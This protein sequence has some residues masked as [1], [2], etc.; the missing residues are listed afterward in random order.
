MRINFKDRGLHGSTLIIDF[1]G[2]PINSFTAEVYKSNG[3]T[4]DPYW[5]CHC[6]NIHGAYAAGFKKLKEAMESDGTGYRIEKYSGTL[7]EFV[8]RRYYK[9]WIKR[10]LY[11]LY[12]WV[13]KCFNK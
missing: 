12:L 10:K 1:K 2:H 5:T 6:N 11:S 13:G 9:S 8:A 7:E 4:F 3:E